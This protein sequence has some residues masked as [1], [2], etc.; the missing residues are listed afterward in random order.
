MNRIFRVKAIS[1]PVILLLLVGCSNTPQPPVEAPPTQLPTATSA[2]TPTELPPPTVTPFPTVTPRSESVDLSEEDGADAESGDEGEAEEASTEEDS[3]ESE[4][5]E[6]SAAPSDSN[7]DLPSGVNVGQLL[8]ETSFSR[9]WPNIEEET[10]VIDTVQGV[11]IFELGP[12][13][14]RFL[15]T[16][17]VDGG[18]AYIEIEATPVEC[19]AQGG[20]GMVFR[21]G[22][23]GYYQFTLFCSG[24][25]SVFPRVDGRPV[26]GSNGSLSFDAAE[27][28]TRRLGVLANGSEITVYVDGQVID[29]ITDS[30]F[31]SG[32]VGMYALTQTGE[33]IIV[34][35]DNLKV[36]TVR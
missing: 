1:V 29:S 21:F 36:W 33:K 8:Y 10:A 16:S 20:Y 19:P 23:D 28:S 3:G 5:E 12:F 25:Y 34:E 4:A 31:E 24:T 13:D 6:G 30:S 14:G 26:G 11:Y 18:N 15:T 27:N 32:E 35:F 9:G 7:S 2:A 17:G 22:D